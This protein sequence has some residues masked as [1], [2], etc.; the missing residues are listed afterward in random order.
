MKASDLLERVALT[1]KNELGPNIEAEYSRSQAYLGAVVLQKLAGQLRLEKAHAEA[2][3][4]D[5][6]ALQKDLERLLDETAAPP[7]IRRD[8]EAL[9]KDGEDGLC[10]LIE[11][12]YGERAALG[13]ENFDALLSRVRRNLR[14]SLD[15][16]LEYAS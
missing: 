10:R 16:R 11:T 5:R 2:E 6:R 13:E 7:A 12:L 8:V 4:S 9:P 3:N 1:L 14:Q 15:R